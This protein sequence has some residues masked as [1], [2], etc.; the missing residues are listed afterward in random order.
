MG[1][2]RYW[3]KLIASVLAGVLALGSQVSSYAQGV[4]DLPAP[5]AMVQ[6]SARFEPA[7]MVGLQLHPKDPFRFN[8]LIERGENELAADAKREE[9]RKLIKYFLASLTI[10]NNDMWV[11]LS[12]YEHERIIPDNFGQTEMGRDLLAQDYL[13][14][15]ITASLIHPDEGMAKDFW[16]KVYTRA[17]E[18]YGTTDIPLDTFNKVWIVPDTA[19]IY[20]R[21]D[22]AIIVENHLKVMMEQDY[23]ALEKNEGHDQP[24]LSKEKPN[25]EMAQLAAEVI[26]EIVIPVLEKEVNEGEHFALLRQVYSAMLMAT[27]FKKTL[28]ESLLGQVYADKSK[29]AGVELNNP[30]EKEEIYQKYLQAYKIGVVDF[31]K[32]DKDGLTQ[33]S[34]SRKYFSGGTK[35]YI[36]K[37]VKEVDS[38]GDL[39]FV[40]RR[41]IAQEQSA[42]IDNVGVYFGSATSLKQDGAQITRVEEAMGIKVGDVFPVASMRGR[43]WLKKEREISSNGTRAYIGADYAFILFDEGPS[44]GQVYEILETPKMLITPSASEVKEEIDRQILSIVLLHYEMPDKWDQLMWSVGNLFRYLLEIYWG[45][46]DVIGW[47]DARVLL[48]EGASEANDLIGRIEKKGFQK[49]L[50]DEVIFRSGKRLERISTRIRN[51]LAYEAVERFSFSGHRPGERF[52]DRDDPLALS[53]ITFMNS[54]PNTIATRGLVS[55]AVMRRRYKGFF[56]TGEF[57]KKLSA[58]KL[59]EDIVRELGDGLQAAGFRDE[60]VDKNAYEWL[61]DLLQMSNFY[62]VWVKRFGLLRSIRVAGWQDKLT[63]KKAFEYERITRSERKT[64]NETTS[65]ILRAFNRI[66]IELS[67]PQ[68]CPKTGGLGIT[69]RGGETNGGLTNSSGSISFW[70]SRDG[71]IFL[72]SESYGIQHEFYP[73]LIWAWSKA[74]GDRMK[75]IVTVDDL[76]TAGLGEGRAELILERLIGPEALRKDREGKCQVLHTDDIDKIVQMLDGAYLPLEEERVSAV[77]KQARQ[78]ADHFRGNGLEWVGGEK[79]WVG[80]LPYFPTH[81]FVPDFLVDYVNGLFKSHGLNVKVYPLGISKNDGEGWRHFDYAQTSHKEELSMRVSEWHQGGIDFDSGL[82][83][84]K[85]KRDGAGIPLHLPMQ[86]PAMMS[87]KGL[88]PKILEITPAKALPIFSELQIGSSNSRAVR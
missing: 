20:H 15:Q 33:S 72:Q 31:I 41:H 88:T 26:R 71:S 5:G 24:G 29:V 21:Y 1:L 30:Q 67:F 61:Q 83:N 3:K 11:N 32:E 42:G 12:P 38:A 14:K 43:G 40:Q 84:L 44:K 37:Q 49:W 45:K 70:E 27:W 56:Y 50:E 73:T 13:L 9:Y 75:G 68:T 55:G 19:T 53:H 82:L 79:R 62:E 69:Q 23:L 39:S 78:N 57:S 81:A 63:L 25:S 18:K 59:R 28:K 76:K 34:I 47:R 64:P 4:L 2:K 52:Y 16:N 58:E 86:D 80:R 17:F 22:T 46:N 6:L 35:N 54:L 60:S 10:P 77:L 66:L 36:L 51:P 48:F 7:L 65:G 8:F 87:I 74:I 85:I